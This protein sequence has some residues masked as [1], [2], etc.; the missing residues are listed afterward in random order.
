MP[1]AVVSFDVVGLAK[2]DTPPR[3]D[4]LTAT[5]FG[6]VGKEFDSA[7]PLSVEYRHFDGLTAKTMWVRDAFTLVPQHSHCFD[8]LTVLAAGTVRAWI[9][10]KLIGD[11]TAPHSFPIPTGT[12]HLFQSLVPST[13]MICLHHTRNDG[14]IEIADEHELTPDILAQLGR[15]A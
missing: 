12:K 13:M 10:C 5:F 15:A 11:F 6:N 3:F 1:Y 7:Q 14:E 2:A 4:G 8:H 9:D